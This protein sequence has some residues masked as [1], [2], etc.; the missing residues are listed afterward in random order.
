[1]VPRR[2]C[3]PRPESTSDD[4]AGTGILS[5]AVDARTDVDER[6]ETIASGSGRRRAFLRAS[7]R[8]MP[9]VGALPQLVTAPLV[10]ALLVTTLLAGCAEPDPPRP[11]LLLITIDTL[12]ADALGTYGYD[13][14]TSPAIDALARRG[15]VFDRAQSTSAWTLPSLASLMTSTYTSTHECWDFRTS[16]S[17]AYTTLAEILADEGWATGGVASHTFLASSYGLAQ[18]FEHYDEQLAPT[19]GAKAHKAITSEQVTDKGLAWVDHRARLGRRDGDER[20]WFLWV[21]YFDPHYIYQQHDG[22]TERFEGGTGAGK[23][24]QGKMAVD[25]VRYDGEIAHTDAQVGRLLDGLAERGLLDD[26]VVVLTSDHG[27]E[28]GDH[29]SK[30]HGRTL[31]REVLRVPLIMAGPGIATGRTEVPVGVVDVLPTLLD[32]FGLPTPR[33]LAGRSLGRALSGGALGDAPLLAEL[34]L[35][36]GYHADALLDG[37]WKLVVDP[38]D[39]SARLFDL[40]ADPLERRDLAADHPDRV[41]RM[42]QGLAALREAARAASRRTGVDDSLDLD[43]DELD[44]LRQLGYVD[45]G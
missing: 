39:D 34:R 8:R 41:A 25:R 14:P 22:L 15:H 37:R 24:A 20:P 26:T 31:Y 44:T 4:G 21:H 33:G 30:H 9:W 7:V 45:D 18:G 35:F 3:V 42:R 5:C 10:T 27:E 28:F 1:M 43:E 11:N 38:D 40:Q 16:L 17:E 23:Q 12:R 19:K 13:Q 29:G 32:L 2:R 6:T 36:D